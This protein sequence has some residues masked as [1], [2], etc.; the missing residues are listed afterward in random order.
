MNLN[1]NLT[2]D[3]AYS[4]VQYYTKPYKKG[5]LKGKTPLETCENGFTSYSNAIKVIEQ[6]VRMGEFTIP[7]KHAQAKD[8]LMK[9][10]EEKR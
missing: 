5:K 4:L 9:M 2:F 1:T 3:K 7:S 6:Y 10:K 8:L